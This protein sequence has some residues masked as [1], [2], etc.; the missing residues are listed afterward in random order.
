[1]KL[2]FKLIDYVILGAILS[3]IS[4]YFYIEEYTNPDTTINYG[5]L[6]LAI[7]SGYMVGYV[8]DFAKKMFK[9]S[10]STGEQ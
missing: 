6:L 8:L 4:I 1:M 7:L 5:T 10:K 2:L 9:Y 3:T